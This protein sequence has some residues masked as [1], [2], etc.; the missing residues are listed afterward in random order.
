MTVMAQIGCYVPAA[1]ASFPLIQQLFA[2]VS[3]DDSI[4]ANVSTFAAEMRETAYILRY[5]SHYPLITVL[6]SHGLLTSGSQEH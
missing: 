3:M 6:T 2:R 1:Y 5:T 4:E